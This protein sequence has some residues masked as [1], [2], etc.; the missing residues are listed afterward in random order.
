MFAASGRILSDMK[1]IELSGYRPVGTTIY[2]RRATGDCAFVAAGEW[3]LVVKS[4]RRTMTPEALA[5]LTVVRCIEARAANAA[6]VALVDAS[7][8]SVGYGETSVYE[9]V[10]EGVGCAS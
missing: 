7:E 6:R 1:T 10:S 4:E 9:V 5:A 2:L 8:G 3:E